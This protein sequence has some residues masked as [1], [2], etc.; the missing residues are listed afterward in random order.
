MSSEKQASENMSSEKKSSEKL[1][2]EKMSS[3]RTTSKPEPASTEE[4][5]EVPLS[6]PVRKGI[7]FDPGYLSTIPGMMKTAQASTS[8]IGFICAQTI[9]K[10]KFLTAGGWYSFV[11]LPGFCMST[12]FLLCYVF[13]VVERFKRLP[14]LV[15][16]MS[17][18]AAWCILFFIASTVAATRVRADKPWA[19]AAFFGFVAMIIFGCEAFIKWH[20]WNRDQLAQGTRS[21]ANIRDESEADP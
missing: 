1:S 17:Y 18:A 13:H 21:D 15:V 12:I 2:K 16:E 11:S 5:D 9:R 10:S 20:I 14:W 8:L 4:G 3:E 6:A 19:A 7:H